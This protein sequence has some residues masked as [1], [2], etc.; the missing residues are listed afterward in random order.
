MRI[1]ALTAFVLGAV[2]PIAAQSASGM[3]A[4]QYYVGSWTCHGGMTADPP[5]KATSTY[6]MDGNVLRQWV[7]VAAGGKMTQPY[8]VAFALSY[9]AKN[10]RYSQAGV[11]NMGNWW[12]SYAPPFTGNAEHW[13]DTASSSG[14]L[15]WGQGVRV[16]QNTSTYT[17]YETKTST[18]PNFK[19]TCTRNS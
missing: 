14:K 10:H 9:D 19:V 4:M 6:T 18:K 11:D 17:G 12:V 3:A 1:I 2:L 5:T 8:Y 15:G 7:V 16:D 13:T